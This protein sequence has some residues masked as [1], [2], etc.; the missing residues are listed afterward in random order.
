MPTAEQDFW[1]WFQQN[2]TRLLHP[3]KLPEQ[4]SNSLFD[5]FFRRTND[6]CGGKI[7]PEVVTDEE[8]NRAFIIFTSYGDE[9]Y[10]A[11]IEKLVAA[12]PSIEG[13]KFIALYPPMPANGRLAVDFPNL[14][15][16]AEQFLFAPDEL[17][18]TDGQYNL[19]LY[20][21]GFVEID[22]ELYTAVTAILFNVLGEKKMTLN[23]GYMVISYLEDL[24]P[25]VR[26]KLIPLPELATYA[27]DD[28]H[29]P[30]S[31]NGSGKMVVDGEEE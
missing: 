26:E 2:S 7:T 6:Y 17:T 9:Q 5:E 21:E 16:T 11:P 28:I 4:E 1:D 13:W 19:E 23:M 14:P 25:A 12:A 30:L 15:I 31:V 3:S 24:A 22:D 10:F 8:N 18:I 27:S 20:V 29:T